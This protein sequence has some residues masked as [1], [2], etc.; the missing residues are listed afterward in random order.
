MTDTALR[1]A[2][3]KREKELSRTTRAHHGNRRRGAVQFP[4]IWDAREREARFTREWL[5]FTREWLGQDRP[6]L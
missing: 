6:R 5:S 4:L 1:E 2:R 3:G